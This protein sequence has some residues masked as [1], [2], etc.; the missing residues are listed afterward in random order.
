MSD[1]ALIRATPGSCGD[2]KFWFQT[3]TIEKAV[4]EEESKGQVVDLSKKR[5]PKM[6]TF[7]VGECRWRP[8]LPDGEGGHGWPLMEETEWCGQFEEAVY[9]EFDETTPAEEEKSDG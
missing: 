4:E 1:A 3:D 6:E 9:L 2:C 5:R 7:E 8:P